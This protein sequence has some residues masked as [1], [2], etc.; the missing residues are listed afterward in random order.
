MVK[1]AV[2]KFLLAV[3]AA[4]L[5]F[6]HC[7]VLAVE[8]LNE[9]DKTWEKLQTTGTRALENME[10]GNAE[11]ALTAAMSLA[12]EFPAGDQRLAKSC[13]ELGRLLSIRARFAEAEPLLEEELNIKESAN[14]SEK[15][16]LIPL[17][18]ALIRFYMTHGTVAKAD[19]LTDDLLSFVLGRYKIVSGELQV[20]VKKGTVLEGWAGTAPPVMRDPLLE[21]SITCDQLG[22]LYAAHK[23][24]DM[25]D[26]LYQASLDIKT[27]ILGK[28]HLSLAGSYD[29]LGSLCEQRDELEDAESYYRDALGITEAIQPKSDPQVFNRLDKLARCLVKEGKL[30]AAEE[31]YTS[32]KAFYKSDTT[33][34]FNE[35]RADYALG[36]IYISLHNYAAAAQVLHRALRLTESVD[37]SSSIS[38]VPYLQRYAYVLYYLGRRGESEQLKAR[39]RSIAPDAVAYEPEKRATPPAKKGKRR[40]SHAAIKHKKR[41]RQR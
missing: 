13:G 18:A 12:R 24:Y 28:Q 31:L 36:S 10:Y 16:K 20:K 33:R 1:Q 32:S 6:S 14:E 23:K 11:R 35:A 19:P 9:K 25:A 4:A 3:G 8:T 39:A 15:G 29:N 21:W 37:G 7:A 38:L 17:T 27:S 40:H 30:E 41:R 34:S 2:K 5:A 26:Q 22:N